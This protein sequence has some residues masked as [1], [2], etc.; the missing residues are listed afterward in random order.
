MVDALSKLLGIIIAILLLFIFPLQESYARQADIQYLNVF[1]STTEFTDAIRDK[2]YITPRMWLDFQDEITQLGMMMDINMEHFSK[3]YDPI[4]DD[5]L[6]PA[7]FHEEFLVRHEITNTAGIME[8][9][10][11]NNTEPKEA[12]TRRYLLKIGDYVQVIVHNRQQTADDVML[13]WLTSS[14]AEWKRIDVSV[15]G[16]VR[17]E[18]Y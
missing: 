9:L 16:M 6:E 5:P 2:G 12:L 15:G 8:V 4:Y 3:Q 17:N 10:F 18:D 7:T 11:P 1:K 13:E 14:F